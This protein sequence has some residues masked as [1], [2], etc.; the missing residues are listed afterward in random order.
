[1]KMK[2]ENSNKI[3]L[4]LIAVLLNSFGYIAAQMIRPSGIIVTNQIDNM[5]PYVSQF[6]LA[7]ML[8][9]PVVLVS[10]ILLW[11]NYKEFR[12]MALCIIATML[13]SIIIY[14]VFQTESIRPDV[15]Q[16]GDVFNSLVSW[17]YSAD[18]PVNSFPSLHVAIPTL[19]TLFVFLHS[20]KLGLA[21]LP[22][23]ILIIL[24]TVF[25]KQHSV[26][27]IAG[28]LI[29]AFFVFHYRHIFDV[30]R[31]GKKKMGSP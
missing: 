25:I 4:L 12:V 23:A 14:I 30:K 8:Y 20:R 19:V 13:I 1:M 31:A 6:V 15:N 2:T 22:A 5:I 18:K 28:A 26:V 10:Y 27:D 3:A 9:L 17:V 16:N 7:Y 11:K 24:S 21:L 29:L